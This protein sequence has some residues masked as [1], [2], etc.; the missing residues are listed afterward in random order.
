MKKVEEE[1]RPKWTP[2]KQT[3]L[4]RCQVVFSTDQ[5]TTKLVNL[6]HRVGGLDCRLTMTMTWDYRGTCPSPRLSRLF[7]GWEWMQFCCN[8]LNSLLKDAM[9]SPLDRNGRKG[10]TIWFC[11]VIAHAYKIEWLSTWLSY[12]AALPSRLLSTSCWSY[13]RDRIF[14]T[15][16]PSFKKNSGLKACSSRKI[17]NKIK[18]SS[19]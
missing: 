4:F 6:H 18:Q 12:L 17:H 16:S 19:A 9:S 15:R 3:R 13:L 1:L 11:P 7:Q 10:L 5:T 2:R 8:S 14:L